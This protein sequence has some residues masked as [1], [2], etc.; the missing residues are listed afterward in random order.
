MRAT[1]VYRRRRGDRGQAAL[2]YVGVLPL[3]LLV[4]VLVIQLGIAVFAVQQ[5]GT[6]ARAAARMA[7]HDEPDRS[8][9]QAGQDAM[10][11]WLA[12][13]ARFDAQAGHDA[14]TVTATVPIPSL[15]PGLLD[16]MEARR[17]ATM[18]IDDP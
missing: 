9:G 8:Y 15:I 4:G 7:S 5:A 12:D 2:E 10:S 17:S 16:G 1:D 18:P 11:S 3:L 14:V 6:A 13:G